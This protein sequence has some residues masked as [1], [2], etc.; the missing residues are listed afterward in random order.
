MRFEGAEDVRVGE[1]GALEVHVGGTVL[2]QPA[3]VLYQEVDGRRVSVRGAYV[4]TG[5][6]SVRFEVGEYDGNRPLVIDPVLVYGTYLAGSD[7]DFAHD[8]AVDA[9]GAA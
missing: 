8:I 7:Q 6:D 3:P 5:I 1:R 2:E 4:V 9:S